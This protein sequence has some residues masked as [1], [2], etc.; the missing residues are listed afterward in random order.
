[1]E[2]IEFA[3]ILEIKNYPQN[4][5]YLVMNVE[6]GFYYCYNFITEKCEWLEP[7]YINEKYT[8]NELIIN[9]ENVFKESNLDCTH[10]FDNCKK[11][12]PLPESPELEKYYKEKELE[13]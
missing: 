7:D 5:R 10:M 6:D 12:T 1:M 2:T 11:L 13:K 3:T 8:N 4:D 9:K